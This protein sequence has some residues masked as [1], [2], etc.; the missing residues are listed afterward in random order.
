MTLTAGSKLGPYEILAPIGAGGMGQVWKARDTRLDRVVAIK[1][2]EEQFSERF[3]REARVVAALNHPHICT[4]FDV[5]PN[6]LVMEYVDGRPLQGPL[7]MDQG[8]KYSAQ[9]CD[10]LDAAHR[11]RDR[12]RDLK[13]ANILVTKSGVKLLDFG[14]AQI[15]YEATADAAPSSPMTRDGMVVGTLQ[16]MSPE[17]LERKKADARSDIYSLGLVLYEMV[18]G[19]RAFPHTDLE[20][21]QYPALERI[22]KTCL[23]RDPDARWQSSREVK[24]ALEWTAEREQISSAASEPHK[25]QHSRVVWIFVGALLSI[26]ALL[27]GRLW[28]APPTNKVIRLAI[29]PPESTVFS[30]ARYTTVPGP[31]FAL[32]PDGNTIVF[33][34][35]SLDAPPTLWLRTM[36]QLEARSLP[37]TE[38]ADNPF[39]SPDGAW[40]GFFADRKLKKFTLL[41]ELCRR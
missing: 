11:K 6:Y 16:Y 23:A 41:T 38:G 8:L 25:S 15:A 26:F 2:S 34:A 29:N 7:P 17:Q 20:K 1:I 30:G 40:V 37:G 35:S 3:E 14:L 13:P 21:L 36:D 24:L 18:T 32:A 22:V 5:G 28:H 12:N 33:A 31:Q 39:W 27:G 19:K 10:A 4:L 9:I